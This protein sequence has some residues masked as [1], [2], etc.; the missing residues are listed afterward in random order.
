MKVAMINIAIQ[1]DL[2]NALAL[3]T[4]SMKA[5]LSGEPDQGIR[6]SDTEDPRMFTRPQPMRAKHPFFRPD[7]QRRVPPRAET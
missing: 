1:E 7:V 4:R 6:C 3:L 2:P 5:F